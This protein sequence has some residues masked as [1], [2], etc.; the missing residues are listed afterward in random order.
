MDFKNIGEN[1]SKNLSSKWSLKILD[2]A[3]QSATDAL[4]TSSK[5]VIQK[6]VEATG[7]LIGNKIADRITIKLVMN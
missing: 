1:I 3:N 2:Y 6:A 4:T 5:G 7:D